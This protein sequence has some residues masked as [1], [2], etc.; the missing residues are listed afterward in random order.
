MS[1]EKP[2]LMVACVKASIDL[3][4]TYNAGLTERGIKARMLRIAD[5]LKSAVEEP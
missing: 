3:L 2:K 5:D 1:E 4:Q